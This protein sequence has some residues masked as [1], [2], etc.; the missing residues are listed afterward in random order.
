MNPV[1]HI[2]VAPYGGF[3]IRVT[4]IPGTHVPGYIPP[5][6]RDSARVAGDS[7]HGI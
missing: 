3:R 7:L 5:S 4:R 2:P 1:A 6:L